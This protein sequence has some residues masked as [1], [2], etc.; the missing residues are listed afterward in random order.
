MQTCANGFVK[1]LGYDA[2]E[3]MAAITSEVG[4]D[5]VTY[6][7]DYYYQNSG[8]RVPFRGGIVYYGGNAGPFYWSCNVGWSFAHWG[9]GGRPLYK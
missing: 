1:E 5:S 4:G 7:S 9:V 8:E 6:Y 3:P 2:S